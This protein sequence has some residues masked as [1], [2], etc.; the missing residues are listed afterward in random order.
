MSLLRYSLLLHKGMASTITSYP[1][2]NILVT[3]KNNSPKNETSMST[4]VSKMTGVLGTK[5]NGK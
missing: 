1:K 2:R 4:I 3:L 5:L